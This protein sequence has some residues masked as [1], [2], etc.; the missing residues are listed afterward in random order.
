MKKTIFAICFLT[1]SASLCFAK[2]LI[3]KTEG[4]ASH[5][6]VVRGI[7]QGCKENSFIIDLKKDLSNNEKAKEQ[8]KNIQA[9]MYIVLGDEAA[10]FA[11]EN[12][13]DKIVLY[14]MIPE[15]GKYNFNKSKSFG[16]DILISIDQLFSYLKS[17]E[18]NIKTAGLLYGINENAIMVQY[19][20]KI[21]SKEGITLIPRGLENEKEIKTAINELLPQVD[22]IIM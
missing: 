20:S 7:A 11:T 14:S 17:I 3:L 9:E 10:S 6:F 5:E 21:A 1:V 2:M 22:I 13:K 19:A 4:A 18:N 16:L 8:V 15:P 12:L